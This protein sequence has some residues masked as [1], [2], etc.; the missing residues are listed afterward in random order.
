MKTGSEYI[1]AK[2][3]MNKVLNDYEF[4]VKSKFSVGNFV[5]ENFNNKVELLDGR[6]NFKVEKSPSYKNYFQVTFTD[7]TWLI[8]KIENLKAVLTCGN[9]V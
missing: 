4:I 9:A 2:L 6:L 7:R 5:I 3:G 1:D 8:F